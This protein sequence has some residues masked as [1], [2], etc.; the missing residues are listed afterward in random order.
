MGRNRRISWAVLPVAGGLCLAALGGC[1]TAT[2][3]LIQADALP[4]LQGR[5]STTAGYTG[6]ITT[7]NGACRGSFTGMLGQPVV[8][9]EISCQDGRH[10]IGTAEITEG[11]FVSGQVRLSDGSQLTVRPNGPD[12]P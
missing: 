10:G 4:T 5:V 7:D 9:L 3:V 8:P 12:T 6:S 11:R 2:P 1:S